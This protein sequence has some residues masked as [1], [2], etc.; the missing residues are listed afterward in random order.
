MTCPNCGVDLALVTLLAERAYLEGFPGAAPIPA[1]PEALVPRI[2]ELLIEQNLLTPEQLDIALKHQRKL[3]DGKDRRLLGEILVEMKLI[4]REVL[5]GI[6]NQQI[7]A[8]HSALQEANRNLEKRVAERTKE[9]EN[10]LARLTELNQIKAN[11]ISNVSHELRTPLAHIKG[12]IELLI[13]EQLGPLDP[14]QTKA[15]EVVQRSYTRLENLIDD[16]IEFSTSSREGIG[17]KIQ[18]FQINQLMTMVL[19]RSRSKAEKEKITLKTEIEDALPLVQGDVKRLGWV[20]IQLVDNGIKFTP[21]GGKVTLK[22]SRNG[23]QVTISVIDTGI[24]IPADRMDEIFVPFH[25]LDGSA[26]RRYGGTGLG[27]ALVKLI[28][29]AHDCEIRIQ[30]EIGKGSTFSFDLPKVEKID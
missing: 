6:I 29:D 13:G 17:L 1:A 10:A 28:L 26:E 9:L 21:Q 8:L 15:L 20:L 30:S 5:D 3:G 25:Q 4:D 16:L 22:S 27:L 7:I 19:E 11:M 18:P 12:Y 24:G 14:E 2:G 23:D